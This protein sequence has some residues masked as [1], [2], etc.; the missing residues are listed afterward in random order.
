[1]RMSYA[2]S[3]SSAPV[4]LGRSRNRLHKLVLVQLIG[5]RQCDDDGTSRTLTLAVCPTPTR[6]V[7]VALVSPAGEH[8]LAVVAASTHSQSMRVL[9]I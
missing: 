9:S 1:M 4:L 7:A 2:A 5:Q 3:A 6:R 8:G